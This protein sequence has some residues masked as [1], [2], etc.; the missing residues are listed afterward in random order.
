MKLTIIKRNEYNKLKQNIKNSLLRYR[1][2][3]VVWLVEFA[4]T[5]PNEVSAFFS[6]YLILPAEI[7]PWG[8]LSNLNR[9]L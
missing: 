8:L 1:E 7:W 5:T 2:Y 4:F 6:I 9:H 3:T